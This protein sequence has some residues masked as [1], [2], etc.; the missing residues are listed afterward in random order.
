MTNDLDKKKINDLDIKTMKKFLLLI[1]LRKEIIDNLKE[2]AFP[3]NF[4]FARNSNGTWRNRFM[5]AKKQSQY[6]SIMERETKRKLVWDFKS[7]KFNINC[8]VKTN[9]FQFKHMVAISNSIFQYE[10]RVI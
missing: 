4:F 9:S 3:K 8:H 10:H 2:A 6:E 1:M 7:V 5:V